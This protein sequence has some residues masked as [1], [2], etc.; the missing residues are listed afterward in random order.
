[1]TDEHKMKEKA[2]VADLVGNFG[3]IGPARAKAMFGGYGIYIEETMVGLVADRV[4]YLKVDESLAREYQ[5]LK[6]PH[7]SYAK[8][9]KRFNM[10]YCQAH[11]SVHQDTSALVEWVEKSLAVAKAAKQTK[12]KRKPKQ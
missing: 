6:L 7:F 3:L 11:A 8:N 10:S 9:G 2:F 1:M 5:A 4:L 12:S